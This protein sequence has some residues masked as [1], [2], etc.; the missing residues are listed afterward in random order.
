MRL[1]TFRLKNAPFLARVRGSIIQGEKGLPLRAWKFINWSAMELLF[2][3]Y[4]ILAMKII[5]YYLFGIMQ[6]LLF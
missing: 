2:V 6:L 1:S 4:S 5:Y 3:S